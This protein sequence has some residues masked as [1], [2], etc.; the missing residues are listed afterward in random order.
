MSLERPGEPWSEATYRGFSGPGQPPDGPRRWLP[1]ISRNQLL[2]GAA[3]AVVL[4]LAVGLWARPN[5]NG[6]T[7]AS[8]EAAAPRAVPIEVDPRLPPGAQPKPAGKLEVLPPGQAQAAQAAAPPPEVMAPLPALPAE[9]P[10]AE[11]RAAAPTS[12]ALQVPPAQ[13]PAIQPPAAARVRAGLD[14]ATARQGAEQMVCSDPG[15]AA[16]DRELARAY[17]RALDSGAAP[18]EIRAE[19]RDWLAIRE[20]AARYSRRA[21]AEAYRQRID[22]LN[23]IA[24]GGGEPPDE[25]GPG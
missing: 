14:C 9:A 25:D 6:K 16:E 22:E 10:P 7:G 23:R 21:V 2:V 18:G 20:D 17:R 3:A 12:P 5:L 15:L 24:D 11:P 8:D 19:Q 1:R 13:A 4:G